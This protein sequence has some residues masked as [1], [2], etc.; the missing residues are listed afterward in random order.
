MVIGITTTCSINTLIMFTSIT[1][2]TVSVAHTIGVTSL[3]IAIYSHSSGWV[4]S[5]LVKDMCCFCSCSR[6][7]QR[8]FSYVAPF[9]VIA[10]F[11][12][13]SGRVK[14]LEFL[15]NCVL[16]RL[17]YKGPQPPNPLNHNRSAMSL[18][19]H[20]ILQTFKSLN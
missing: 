4:S 18:Q 2:L 16:S 6:K 20:V 3:V 15:A 11:E 19:H 1:S 13:G 12:G 9:S 5:S 14:G 10:L 17:R 7:G 8:A